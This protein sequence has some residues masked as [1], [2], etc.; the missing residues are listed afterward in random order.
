MKIA[1]TQLALLKWASKKKG[2]VT[3]DDAMAKFECSRQAATVRLNDARSR[4][5]LSRKE[6]KA[7][8][9]NVRHRFTITEKGLAL[10]K[11]GWSGKGRF[12]ELA[13]A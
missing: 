4:R 6:E 5:W 1:N 11:A 9:P 12:R 3:I 8:G 2:G 10:A 13:S 7:G